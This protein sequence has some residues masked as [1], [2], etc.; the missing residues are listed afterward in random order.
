MKLK[1]LMNKLIG[2]SV[3][4][5]GLSSESAEIISAA[6]PSAVYWDE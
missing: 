5:A 6:N 1:G 2:I 3:K 4:P